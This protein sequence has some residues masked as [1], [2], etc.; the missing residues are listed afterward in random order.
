MEVSLKSVK[1]HSSGYEVIV[2][3]DKTISDYIELPVFVYEKLKNNQ[4]F[5]YAFF[6]DLLR[7]SLLSVYGGVWCDAT[8]YLTDKIHENLLKQDF[9]MFQRGDKPNDYKYWH[10][11]NVDYFSW[12]SDW[13]VNLLSSFIASK[14]NNILIT[15]LTDILLNYWKNEDNLHHYFVLHILYNEIID[16][17]ENCEII[18]DTIPNTMSRY[19]HEPY[20]D[21]LWDKITVHNSIH[22]LT[23]YDKI[24]PN[25]IQQYILGK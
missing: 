1:K 2:L 21:K 22:K 16:K 19:M 13:K 25:S 3:N 24:V 10:K 5:T 17:Y 8:I 6:S 9:F 4:Q 11:H 23:Y 12:E 14:P 7:V 18:C 20:S 15:E